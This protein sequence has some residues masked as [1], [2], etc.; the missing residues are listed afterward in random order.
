MNAIF[1]YCLAVAAEKVDVLVHAFVVLSNHYHAVITDKT[2]NAPRFMGYLNRL[3]ATCVNAS[4]GRWE[5]LW[6]TGQP[7]LVKLNDASDV[8]R[9]VVYTITNPVS[10][11]LVERSELW[12]GLR[13]DPTAPGRTGSH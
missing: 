4:L 3:V 10:S 6:A 11:Y 2:D 9:E 13:M 8:L 1:L 7:S 5:N 12:P